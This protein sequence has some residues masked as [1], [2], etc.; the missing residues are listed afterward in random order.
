MKL[1]KQVLFVTAATFFI[2]EGCN[3]D[4]SVNQS[5]IGT[6]GL[7]AEKPVSE[8]ARFC[9]SHGYNEELMANDPIF[10]ANQA[11]IE[12]FTTRFVSLNP[13]LQTRAVVTIP[14]VVH[15]VYK[16]AAE[17]ISDAQVQSQIDILNADFRKLNADVSKVPTAFQ[18][19]VADCEV[20]FCLAKRSPTGA[21]TT[22]I[23]RVLTKKT[24]FSTNNGVKTASGGGVAPWD[25]TKYLNIWACT[26]SGGILGYAQF[27]GGSISTDG[28]VILNKA[29]GSTG[30]AAAP[31]NKG[32]T[33]THEVGHWL[34][35]RHIWGDD[36]GAC[37]GSDLV[38]DTPNQ[39]AE[40]YG[41]PAAGKA[42]CSNGG[43]MFMNYMDYT[44]DACMFMFSAG[45]KA[46]MQAT[47]VSGGAHYS[48][49][50][51]GRCNP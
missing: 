20:Q 16:T 28:V 51:S 5:D 22:G 40:N 9:A 15:V 6:S 38:S 23:N 2:A 48:I 18:S 10:K 14:V 41:C 44:N 7:L 32:R 39:G 34:N 13:D 46:R 8:G 35:L 26:M 33:A 27:P 47:L 49:T 50:I 29:F 45:Q 24:S 42:S 11:S 36:S 43:D 3:K 25:A 21:V 31:F 1:V 12:E 4:N 17:N 19:L 30:T 37:T